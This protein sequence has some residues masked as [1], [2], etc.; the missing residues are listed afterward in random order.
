MVHRKTP[1]A[2]WAAFLANGLNGLNACVT[3]G[4]QPMNLNSSEG[5][6]TARRVSAIE[7]RLKSQRL[8]GEEGARNNRCRRIEGNDVSNRTCGGR[9]AKR[10]ILEVSMRRGV[11][12]PVVRKTLR[13]VGT[14]A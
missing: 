6:G 5:R 9:A 3:A 7:P 10:A 1:E 11:V 12:V 8:E 14:G 2:A 13:R 4:V